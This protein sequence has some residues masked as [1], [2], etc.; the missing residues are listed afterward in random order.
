MRT[1]KPIIIKEK[2]KRQKI[3][4]L[5]LETKRKKIEDNSNMREKIAVF[6]LTLIGFVLWPVSTVFEL[7]RYRKRRKQ[8]RNK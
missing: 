7:Q 2:P 8:K 5:R 4:R 1:K 6:L 3:Q